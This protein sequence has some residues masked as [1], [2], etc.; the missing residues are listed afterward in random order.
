M[1]HLARVIPRRDIGPERGKGRER[2][3]REEGEGTLAERRA[4]ADAVSCD[5][6]FFRRRNLCALGLDEPCPTFRPD[7]PD[8]L[9]P[10]RQPSLLTRAGGNGGVAAVAVSQPAA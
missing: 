10:P 5:D 1:I 3:S 7:S 6:C 9:V 4:R 2:P 8:G